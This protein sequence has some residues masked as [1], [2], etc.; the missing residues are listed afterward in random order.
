MSVLQKQSDTLTF[1]AQ[2]FL[3]YAMQCRAMLCCAALWACSTFADAFMGYRNRVLYK[4]TEAAV[5]AAAFSLTHFPVFLCS[6]C[7]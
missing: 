3:S 2:F 5:A 7:D 1:T 6:H 4:A